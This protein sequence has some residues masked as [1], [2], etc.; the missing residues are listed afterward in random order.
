MILPADINQKDEDGYTVLHD[1]AMNGNV[2]GIKQIMRAPNADVNVLSN[3]GLTPLHIAVIFNR[4]AAIKELASI[5][6]VSL[7]A[8]SPHTGFT[9]LHEA[10]MNNHVVATNVLC[11]TVGVNIRTTD[12]NG[13]TPLHLAA[14]TGKGAV[15]RTMLR[16]KY[17]EVNVRC[18]NGHTPLHLAAKAANTTTCYILLTTYGIDAN[19]MED[20]K[21]M[22]PL[23]YAAACGDKELINV[24]TSTVYQGEHIV[25]VNPR[26]IDGHTPLALAKAHK[27]QEAAKALRKAGAIM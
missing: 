22:T 1:A 6:G 20:T 25:A 5:P 10:V 23:H 27:K 21:Q 9:P 2:E 3:D 13:L 26:S 17:T 12:N 14:F 18:V 16:Y 4:G 15:L 8:Q 7:N 24:F 11:R 19:A